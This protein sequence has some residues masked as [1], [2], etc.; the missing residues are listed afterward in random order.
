MAEPLHS[1]S[2]VSQISGPA[3][4]QAGEDPSRN[5]GNRDRQSERLADNPVVDVVPIR[6]SGRPRAAPQTRI[7]MACSSPQTRIKLACS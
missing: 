6:P 2:G 7:K 4:P 1:S 3:G 5:S